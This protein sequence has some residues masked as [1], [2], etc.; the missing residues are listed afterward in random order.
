MTGLQKILK[1]ISLRLETPN[2]WTLHNRKYCNY[3][4]RRDETEGSGANLAGRHQINVATFSFH[5]VNYW[6]IC[7]HVFLDS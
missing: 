3:Y 5:Q 2:D 4:V 7:S 6:V 1:L